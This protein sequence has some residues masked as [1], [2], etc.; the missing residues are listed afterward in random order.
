[1]GLKLPPVTNTLIM[2]GAYVGEEMQ[3]EFGRIPPS[4]LPVGTAYLIEHQLSNLKHREERWLALPRDF[5]QSKAHSRIIDG[6]GLKV[7]PVD[8]KR[9][10]G[11]A[12]FDCLLCMD[13][14]GPVEVIHGDTLVTAYPEQAAD[15][16]SITTATEY[17]RWGRVTA[18]AGRVLSIDAGEIRGGDLPEESI[19]SGYFLFSQPNEL[20]R[21]LGSTD[22]DF[23]A[24]LDKYCK[25]RAVGASLAPATLDFGHQ[26]TYYSSRK[27]LASARHFNA[28]SIGRHVVQKSSTDEVKLSAE[29]NWLRNV[30]IELQ[31]FTARLIHDARA[32]LSVGYGTLY[33]NYP[34]LAELTLARPSELV[35][36]RV[37]ASVLEFLESA[38][39]Y[40]VEG[41]DGDLRWLVIDKLH[42]RLDD[43]PEFLPDRCDLLSINGER[44]GSLDALIKHL[45]EIIALA[46]PLPRSIM[47]GDLCF[48]NIMFDTRSDRIQLIDPRGI[49]R[50][51]ETIFGD[52]RYDIA[53]FGHSVLGRYDEIVAGHIVS[54]ANGG[55][56]TL[57][58][59][60]EPLGTWL[61]RAY[62]AAQIGTVRF[63][64]DVISASIISLFLS[65]IPLHSENPGRQQTLFANALYLYQRFFPRPR[66]CESD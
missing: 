43:Y 31:P 30:P 32:D 23:L 16:F 10:L 41:S 24:T 27:D 35:W 14:D 65:M 11:R 21:L 57:E 50:G 47:H 39:A 37:F 28:I 7:V 18:Q 42:D 66:R 2:S 63:D 49:V 8:A 40:R 33:G 17:Y 5:I 26:K 48:S 46:G 13:L 54:T 20:L 4:F 61:E 59:P 64:D 12:L 3:A 53:K 36:K 34:T 19:L 51:S 52:L 15:L 60:E 38:W 58:F 6:A 56:F 29:A 25:A 55:D 62:L 1:M 22:F 45:E 9:S 44:V